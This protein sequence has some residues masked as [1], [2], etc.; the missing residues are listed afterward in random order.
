[1]APVRHFCEQAGSHAAA[2]ACWL[3][4]RGLRSLSVRM[5]QHQKNAN[6]IAKWLAT[7]AEVK[8][9]LHPAFFHNE[10]LKH[11]RDY[12]SG[13]PGPFTVELQPCSQ[14]AFDAFIDALN[15]FG[16]GTSWGGFESLVMPALS[17]EQR[18]LAILP[19]EGR[20]VRFHIGLEDNSDLI[21]DLTKAF[22]CMKQF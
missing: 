20:L 10:Q 3:A 19:D 5:A 14:Q 4:L 6:V 17:H 22:N 7:R 16:L 13:C 11:W 2:D 1:M 12:F 8:T 15:L 9:L 18:K 21:D